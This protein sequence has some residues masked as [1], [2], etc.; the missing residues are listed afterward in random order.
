[1]G[2]TSVEYELLSQSLLLWALC[3]D[4]N[5][6]LIRVSDST[7]YTDNKV[8]KYEW[9]IV[10]LHL[11][12]RGCGMALEIHRKEWQNHCGQLRGI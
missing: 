4:A 12:R 2:S 6:V 1:M 10:F 8:S 7:P 9:H 11:Q 3:T 5:D